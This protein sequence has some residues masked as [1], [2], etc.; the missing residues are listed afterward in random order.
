MD[1]YNLEREIE[2][3]KLSVRKREKAVA[4]IKR[5]RARQ[6]RRQKLILVLT[7]GVIIAAIAFIAIRSKTD[8][9]SASA[10]NGDVTEVL[11]DNDQA[12]A[13]DNEGNKEEVFP[14]AEIA[15]NYVEVLDEDIDSAYGAILD[16]NNNKIIAGR[17]A[18]S[19]ME[20]A[21][22]TKVMTLIVVLENVSDI[23][24]TYYTFDAGLVDPLIKEGA[25]RVGYEAGDTVSVKDM[26]YGLILWSGADCAEGLAVATAGS[27]ENFVALMNAKAEELGLKNTH[28]MNTWGNS[29]DNHYTTCQEMAMIMNYAIKNEKARQ[30]LATENY[31]V[32][33]FKEAP[34]GRELKSTMWSRMY[35][36]EVPGV[37]ILGGK[38]GYTDTA[39]N[40]LVSYASKGDNVYICVTALGGGR[41]KPVFDCFKYYE[42]YLPADN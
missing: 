16:V 14:Y 3:A 32:A 21:S 41:Y 15:D 35:G 5:K 13:A 29:Q 23:D 10:D 9:V 30:I 28:F 7:V 31:T 19:I 34:E 6:L 27:T 42:R 37:Q 11:A 4:A 24:N 26:L 2:L 40:C 36:T 38:T 17:Q 25:S 33:G 39:R 18:T 20:P 12:D 8:K 22:M 1:E